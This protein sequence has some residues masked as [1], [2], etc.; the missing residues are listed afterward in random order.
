MRLELNSLI[1]ADIAFKIQTV[2]YFQVRWTLF[3]IICINKV[4]NNSVSWKTKDP[5]KLN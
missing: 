4:K 2:L 1:R 5:Q 3:G